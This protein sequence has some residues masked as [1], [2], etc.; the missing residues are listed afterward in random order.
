VINAENGQVGLELA[1]EQQPD[2]IILDLR[3]PVMDGF[4][5]LKQVRGDETLKQLQVIVSSASVSQLDQQMSLEAGG[6]AFL[7]K[8]VQADELFSLLAEHLQLTWHYEQTESETLSISSTDSTTELILPPTEDL[9][10]LLELA[11]DGLLIKLTGT[12]RQIGQQDSRYQPFIERILQ[13]A[14]QF[15]SDQI[16][17]L[18]QLHLE[19]ASETQPEEN[20]TLS[21]QV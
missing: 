13:L 8:P 1:R 18:I 17:E 10:H 19:K 14:K 15:Q 21:S 4:E 12:A 7:S 5:M 2:L 3:M 16:E 20:S 9:Q 11:Q 6:D